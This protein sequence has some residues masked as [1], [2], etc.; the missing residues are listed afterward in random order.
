MKVLFICPR[1]FNYEN[2]ITDALK[3]IG[4]TVDYF[5]EK[6]FNNVFFKMILRLWKKSRFVRWT[7]NK[8]ID[9]ILSQ[10]L[11]DYDYVFVL[12][13]ESLTQR[14][15]L[16]L[17]KKYT[18]AKFVYYAWDSIRNYAHIQQYLYLFDKV[19][20]FDDQ[21]A[22]NFSSMTHLPLFF[23]PEFS[24]SAAESQLAGRKGK[25]KIAFLGS[26]HSDRYQLLGEIYSRYK[27]KYRL[28]FILY[29]PSLIILAGFI[30]KNISNIKKYK[31]YSFTLKSRSKNEVADFFRSADAILDIQH[32]GQTGLTM[33]TIECLPLER[34]MITTNNSVSCYAF[35]CPENFFFLDRTTKFIDEDFFNVP[36]KK[37]DNTVIEKYSIDAWVRAICS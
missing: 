23:S 11:D 17:K 16:K 15:L 31:L 20:T 37:V 13:G 30:F 28:D 8:H 5:D 35:Y 26:V 32:P 22:K 10:T 4:A 14:L 21:D 33:R 12:K 36:F 3:R 29:F 1:F 7:I 27:D 2:E 24:N 19:Y 6:P 18:R 25:P 9:I 34:K